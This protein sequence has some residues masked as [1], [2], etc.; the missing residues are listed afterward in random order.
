MITCEVCEAWTQFLDHVKN[1]CSPTAFG[2]WI[3]PI[4]V[5][6]SS[7]TEITLKV[8]NIFFKEYLLS[9]FKQELCS[10]LPVTE[11]GEPNIKFIIEKQERKSRPL[12]PAAPAVAVD[13]EP[14]QPQDNLST[15][16]A[17]L[18][19]AYR[20]ETFIEGHSN[21][22]VKSAAIGVANRP[23]I[24]YNPLFIHGW[25]GLGKT[26][27]LH[28]IGHHIKA[29]HKHLRV[30]CITIEGFVN[31]LVDCLRN[32]TIDRMKRM[33]R[34]ETDVLLIDDMQFLQ[35]RQNFEEEVC[36]TI[37]TLINQQKQ[38]VIT[39]DKPPSELKLSER[40]IAR[41]EWGL[42]ANVGIPDLE[43]RVAIL[44]HKAELRG[45]QIPS[46]VAFHIAE[47]IHNNIRQLEGALNRL[48]A[49]S[50]LMNVSITEEFV[51][52]TLR[53]MFQLQPNEKVSIESILKSVASVFEVRI[54]DLRSAT[55]MKNI[56]LPR[57]VAMFLAK[58]MVNESLVMI[59]DAF[60]RTHSTVIHACNSIE[61]EMSENE[62]LRRQIDMVRQ[63]LRNA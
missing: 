60:G 3:A 18:N 43:T 12:S 30:R 47:H 33:F 34:S 37:D 10:F 13:T 27:L 46:N 44:Q 56:A 40:M 38:V 50:R 48:S 54:T 26:H 16:E 63:H 2:N 5:V 41:L 59:A 32:K 23:G 57:Q 1:R 8:P 53:D 17:K 45:L 22:F 24:S 52:K 42:V 51:E 25:V 9:N 11:H 49:Y 35:N 14:K 4:E 28:S 7:P 36:N 55:R 29:H 58:E 61:K 19:E 6:E 62:R 20:F 21:Q 15:Y 31:Q 39:C